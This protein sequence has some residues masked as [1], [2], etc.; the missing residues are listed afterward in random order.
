VIGRSVSRITHH[1]D[2]GNGR[3]PNMVGISTGGLLQVINFSG[4]QDPDTDS[5]S[6]FRFSHHCGIGDFG[7]FKA[8]LTQSPADFYDTWRNDSPSRESTQCM[9]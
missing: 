8:F 6:L 3:R 9:F 4:D 2:R 1:H 5:G 7:R